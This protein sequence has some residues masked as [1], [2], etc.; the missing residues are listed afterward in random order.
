MISIVV[1]VMAVVVSI[2]LDRQERRH[3]LAIELEFERLEWELPPAKP[4]PFTTEAVLKIGLGV[5]LLVFG[6]MALYAF[7]LLESAGEKIGGP[8]YVALFFAVGIALITVGGK[9]LRKRGSIGNV[10]IDH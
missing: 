5:V 9:G 4:K 10:K 7:W 6:G 2:V 3:Q 8:Y 1:L